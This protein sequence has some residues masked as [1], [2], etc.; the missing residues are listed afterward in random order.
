ML[1]PVVLLQYVPHW[2]RSH[3][4]ATKPYLM[5][6][7]SYDQGALQGAIV[8][9]TTSHENL[10]EVLRRDYITTAPCCCV[11]VMVVAKA[12]PFPPLSGVSLTD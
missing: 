7:M 11:Q 12:D 6:R 10:L 9:C 4:V 3:R 8:F 2:Q 1:S 5:A